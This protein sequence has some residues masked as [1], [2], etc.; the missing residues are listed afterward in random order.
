[1][2]S[3]R[4]L[5]RVWSG[6]H[7]ISTLLHLD[8]GKYFFCNSFLCQSYFQS[9]FFISFFLIILSGHEIFFSHSI[10]KLL[11]FSF[12][13]IKYF[14]VFFV[15]FLS[16]FFMASSIFRGEVPSIDGTGSSFSDSAKNFKL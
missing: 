13:N 12:L 8:I 15:S 6:R 4:C 9:L 3:G 1:M 7:I 5:E 10:C 14:S 16:I 11:L 2:V